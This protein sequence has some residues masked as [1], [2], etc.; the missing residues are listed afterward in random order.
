MGPLSYTWSILDRSVIT[1]GVT[2]YKKTGALGNLWEC[3]ECEVGEGY[4]HY[5]VITFISL[6]TIKLAHGEETQ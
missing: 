3:R 5:E 1:Q 2:V 4:A 6:P